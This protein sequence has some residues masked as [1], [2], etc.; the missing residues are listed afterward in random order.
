MN[1][2]KLLVI[3]AGGGFYQETEYLMEKLLKLIENNFKV[4]YLTSQ[5]ALKNKKLLINAPVFL[6]S[7]LMTR[8]VKYLYQ[9]I[10]RLV[11]A[12]MEIGKIFITIN[13]DVV[14]WIGDIIG[15]PAALWAKCLFKEVVFIESVTRVKTPSLTGKIVSTLRLA[16]KIYVQWPEGEKIYKKAEYKGWIL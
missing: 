16:D 10:L 9:K 15:I 6:I 13:P 11:R 12:F 2:K 3:V 1:K 8:N 4:Y 14:L 5:R 7:P